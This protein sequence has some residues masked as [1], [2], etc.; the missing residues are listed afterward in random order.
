MSTKKYYKNTREENEKI[1]EKRNQTEDKKIAQKEEQR[2]SLKAKMKKCLIVFS[3]IVVLG[4]GAKFMPQNRPD[5]GQTMDNQQ[6]SSISGD[7]EPGKNDEQPTQQVTES[8]TK[9]TSSK[10]DVKKGQ[11][12]KDEV[13]HTI[14]EK[15]V[16]KGEVKVER[17]ETTKIEVK[18]DT[19]EEEITQNAVKEA[20]EE[21]INVVKGENDII[22]TEGNT[23]VNKDSKAVQKSPSNSN[24]SVQNQTNKSKGAPIDLSGAKESKEV[25]KNTKSGKES[26]MSEED[27]ARINKIANEEI[28]QVKVQSSN[29]APQK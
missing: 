23:I 26:A 20:K 17:E 27:L 9:K 15:N 7:P 12:L 6:T 8:A 29:E 3:T 2:K 19:K 28:N 13:E 24:T 25:N 1:L 4:L 22:A 21:N 5:P 10:V 16:D 11:D 18:D 14:T